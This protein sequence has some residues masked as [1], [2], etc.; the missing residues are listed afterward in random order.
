MAARAELSAAGSASRAA[1]QRPEAGQRDGGA[2]GTDEQLPAGEGTRHAAQCS[3]ARRDPHQGPP[4]IFARGSCGRGAGREYGAAAPAAAPR[5]RT[6]SCQRH[7]LW[8]PGAGSGG[9]PRASAACAL[10]ALTLAPAASAADREITVS[11][12]APAAWEGRAALDVGAVRSGHADAVRRL[13]RRRVR[14]DARPR[15]RA[16]GRCRSS[17]R[18]ARRRHAATSTCT[19]TAAMRSAS[20]GRPSPSPPAIAAEEAVD[21]PAAS[22]SYLVAAVSFAHR[23]RGVR[24]PRALAPRAAAVP[25]HR[26]PARASGAARQRPSRRRGLAA[27]RRD[28]PA[29]PRPARRRLSRLRRP[30]DVREPDRDRGLVRRRTPLGRARSRLG[31]LGGQPGGGLRRGRRRAAGHQ[32]TAGLRRPAALVAADRA[33][34]AARP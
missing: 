13:G 2:A 5:E 33:R 28:E 12:A 26:P 11:A 9:L 25:G 16:P 14:H 24:R 4:L 19:S 15:R 1:G 21:V 27:G 29:R 3:P 31:R 18:G 7:R 6:A 32:R 34:P 23:H 8:P 20:P 17:S 22:G 10:V 30:G